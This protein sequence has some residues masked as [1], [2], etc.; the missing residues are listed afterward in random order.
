MKIEQPKYKMGE[1]VWI[2]EYDE[3]KE[4]SICFIGVYKDKKEF[5]YG[6]H[7]R[8][9]SYSLYIDTPESKIFETKEGLIKSL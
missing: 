3:I 9:K 7:L 8:E 6:F 1:K 5:Y 2:I 4:V